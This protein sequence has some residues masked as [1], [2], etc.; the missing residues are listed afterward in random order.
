MDKNRFGD[1]FGERLG[2][3]SHSK[4]DEGRERSVRDQKS[5]PAFIGSVHHSSPDT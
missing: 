4:G 2:D 5:A 3:E 1:T